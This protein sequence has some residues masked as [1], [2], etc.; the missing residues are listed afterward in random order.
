MK[1]PICYNCRNCKTKRTAGIF[2]KQG[3]FKV[4][5]LNDMVLFT[6]FDF[7]CIDYVEMVENEDD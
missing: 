6:P 5:S 1:P 7:D 3:H 4:K 2:C